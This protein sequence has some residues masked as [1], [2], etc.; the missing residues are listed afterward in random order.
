M[1]FFDVICRE[2]SVV[3]KHGWQNA[4]THPRRLNAHSMHALFIDW[5]FSLCHAWM[6]L[7]A[8]RSKSKIASQVLSQKPE[9]IFVV[10]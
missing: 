1:L 8:S 9:F 5:S 10:L 7:H 6:L 4:K 2:K 3:P